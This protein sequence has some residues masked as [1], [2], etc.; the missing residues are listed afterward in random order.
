MDFTVMIEVRLGF[1]MYTGT[2][3]VLGAGV[4]AG[5]GLSPTW[6]VSSFLN[7]PA[8]LLPLG[9]IAGFFGVVLGAVPVLGSGVFAGAG[10]IIGTPCE[11]FNGLRWRLL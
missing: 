10:V 3:I 6:L 11:T 8:W 7:P 4:F 9:L 1:G 5:V 2:G